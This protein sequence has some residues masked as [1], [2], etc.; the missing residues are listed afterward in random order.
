MNPPNL[1]DYDSYIEYLKNYFLFKNSKN[2]RFNYTLWSQKLNLA[3][4]SVLTRIISGD[5]TP[6][7]QVLKSFFEYFKFSELEQEYFL[8]LVRMEKETE[9]S[10]QDLYRRKIAD[11]RIQSGNIKPI[12][13]IQAH[14]LIIWGQAHPEEVDKLLSPYGFESILGYASSSTSICLN[15][16]F[17]YQSNLGSYSQFSFA[18]YCK[19]TGSTLSASEMFF[20]RLYASRNEVAQQFQEW[21]S[22]YQFSSME[23]M[24]EPES[25]LLE[26]CLK[27]QKDEVLNLSFAQHKKTLQE[28]DQPND[29]YGYNALLGASRGFPMSFKSKAIIR[30]FDPLIDK[31]QWRKD[32]ELGKVL[33]T[34]QFRPAFWTYQS[35]FNAIIYPHEKR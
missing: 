9:K 6:G 8:T 28:A 1:F 4:V 11:L 20:S 23:A 2:S 29:I 7:A 17:V 12:M 19:R 27:D 13:H 22:P 24:L 21:G 5:R 16:A 25:P 32:S 35:E 26:F 30:E 3:N 18:N 34:I 10:V 33:D 15:G 31:C 14:N